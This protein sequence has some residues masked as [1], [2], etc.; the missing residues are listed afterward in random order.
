MNSTYIYNLTTPDKGYT[1]V[2]ISGSKDEAI[3]AIKIK[4]IDLKLDAHILHINVDKVIKL[5]NKQK[6]LHTCTHK[7][8]VNYIKK[9][10]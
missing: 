7:R 5:S 2:T 4:M 10:D 9:E 1:F 3:R 6:F 8:N